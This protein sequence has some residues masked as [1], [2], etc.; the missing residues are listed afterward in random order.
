[1]TRKRVVVTGISAI[2]PLGLDVEST[3]EGIL[4]GKSGIKKITSFDTT[5]FDTD[6]AG[7][8]TDFN[9]DTYIQPK[10]SKRMDRFTQL[11]VCAAMQ[12]IE[13]SGYTITAENADRVGVILGVGLGGLATI[14]VFHS[15]LVEA[16][17][18]RVS[19]FYIPMLISNIAPGQIA[20]AVGAKGPNYVLTSACASATHSIG[21]AY[22][23]IVMGRCDAMI[24][25]GAESTITPMGI[26]GFTSM[27][28]LCTKYND[29]PEK[30]SRPFDA[31]RGGFVMGEGA[32]M[33]LLES[34]DSALAR[35]AHIYAEVVGFGAS[36]DANHMV[37][38]LETGEGMAL[39][40][41]RALQDA[42]VDPNEIDSINAHGTSTHANDEAETKA[43]KQVFGDHAKNIAICSNKSQ[44]GHLLGA[45][46]GVESVLS[47]LTLDTGMV[48][49]TIN[50]ENP[51]PVCDLNYMPDGPKKL[52]P[53]YVLCSNFGF[54][55][56][57]ASM[58]YKRYEA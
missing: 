36:D 17:P 33:L 12:L 31:E 52:D 34:L 5:G 9:P 7:E 54:G 45:A 1:M 56:T 43:I 55:G 41:K 26:S 22:T 39:A 3:W 19:P 6:I 50:L 2:T 16:G 38:P 47:V 13:N 48:P 4:A 40:M 8:I 44:L 24:T 49:G 28:A 32:G 10:Q 58:L 21:S 51:D 30:A 15:K 42:Q 27:K 57:N 29:S 35:G 46:G 20:I 53:K 11:S 25:G 23:E 37:A 18:S 14:E